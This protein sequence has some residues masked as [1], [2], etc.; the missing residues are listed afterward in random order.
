M[1]TLA[2]DTRPLEA[3]ADRLRRAEGAVMAGQRAELADVVSG[4]A[5]DA[6][7]YP[8]PPPGSTYTRT[9]A[10]GDGWSTEGPSGAGPTLEAAAVN[11]VPY[12]RWVMGE[13]QAAIHAGR[14]R[15]TGRIAKQWAPQVAERLDA[16]AARDLEAVL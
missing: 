15:T 10:L 8:P 12:A 9:G 2:P 14:W 3:L 16:R 13:D 7:L 1:I 4:V 6:S 11:S 5:L